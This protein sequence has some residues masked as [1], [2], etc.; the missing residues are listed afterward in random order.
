MSKQ[1][2][3]SNPSAEKCLPVTGY[4]LMTFLNYV[5]R[6]LTEL[7]WLIFYSLF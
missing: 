5:K 6:M 7:V 1:T 3:N 4:D 2:N